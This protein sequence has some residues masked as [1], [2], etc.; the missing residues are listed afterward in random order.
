MKDCDVLE[1]S[2]VFCLP[3]QPRNSHLERPESQIDV[4]SLFVDMTRDIPFHTHEM[5]IR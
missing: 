5:T 2:L 1:L 3:E 4:T